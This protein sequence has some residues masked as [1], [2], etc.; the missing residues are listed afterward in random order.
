MN[1]EQIIDVLETLSRS[2]GRYGRLLD[3][4]TEEGIEFLVDQEFTDAVDMIMFLEG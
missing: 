4:I 1:R 3:S 2:Q